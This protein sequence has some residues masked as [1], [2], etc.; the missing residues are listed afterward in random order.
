MRRPPVS[1]PAVCQLGSSNHSVGRR[2][3][4]RHRA[5]VYRSLPSRPCDQVGAPHACSDKRTAAPLGLGSRGAH[6]PISG[7]APGARCC[8]PLRGL[9][10]Y[11]CDRRRYAKTNTGGGPPRLDPLDRPIVAPVPLFATPPPSNTSLDAMSTPSVCEKN[12]VPHTLHSL[13]VHAVASCRSIWREHMVS[14]NVSAPRRPRV[15]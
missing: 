11:R 5:R 10:M 2:T 14:T 7:L 6:V 9:G 4:S 3:T 15:S 13:L 8:R 12:I 1:T